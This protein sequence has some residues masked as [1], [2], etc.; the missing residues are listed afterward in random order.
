MMKVSF[1]LLLTVLWINSFPQYIR[2]DHRYL[3]NRTAGFVVY[4]GIPYYELP[5][6]SIYRPLM[7]ARCMRYPVFNSL[8][9]FNLAVELGP[10][11]GVAFADEMNY[12]FG[13]FVN[14][15]LSFAITQWDMLSLVA[16]AGPHYISIETERQAKG[17][18]FS[19]NLMIAYRRKLV[20]NADFYEVSV[21]TGIRHLS[22]AG[23]KEPN[24]GIDNIVMGIGFAK[25]L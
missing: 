10:Q 1:L 5:E 14:L 13:F 19:D 7:V 16:G 3:N 21:Y 22:N 24:K 9:S 8:S 23:I 15:N 18:T 20:M 25:I 17:F 12:E 11:A 4:Y 6:G 2:S